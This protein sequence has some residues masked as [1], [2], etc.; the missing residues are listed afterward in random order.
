[1]GK[2]ISVETFRQAIESN[3]LRDLDYDPQPVRVRIPEAKESL[4]NGLTSILHH[5]LEWLPEYDEIANW[6]T[7]N[8]RKG[9]VLIGPPGVG[10]TE[11]CTKVIPLL[12]QLLYSK[13]FSIYSAATL[14]AE[15]TYYS[16]LHHRLVVVDDF[17]IEGVFND[18]GN[19]HVVFSEIV[20]SIE[21]CGTLLIATTKLT[22]V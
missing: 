15:Q 14:C 13:I 20:D 18:F 4:R 8:N 7:D 3:R 21:R 11:I 16:A 12:F 10:K 9:L 2:V 5:E 22:H 1:M 19:P 17:G 6:L